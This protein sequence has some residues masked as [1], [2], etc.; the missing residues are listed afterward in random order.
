MNWIVNADLPTPVLF[1][2]KKERKKN[3]AKRLD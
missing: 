1:Q 2:G 3:Q